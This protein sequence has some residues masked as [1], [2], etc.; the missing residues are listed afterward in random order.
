MPS[1]RRFYICTLCFLGLLVATCDRVNIAVAAPSI[2]RERGWNTGQMGL[3]L[4]AFY[5]GYVAFMVP[6]GIWTDRF[7]PKR[8][9]AWGVSWWSTFTALTPV[10]SAL[11]GLCTVRALMGAGE[12]ATI[13]SIG[14]MLARW[15]APREYSRASALAW[16]GGYAGSVLAFPVASVILSGWGWRA[17]FYVFAGLGLLWLVLWWRIASDGVDSGSTSENVEIGGTAST[18]SPIQPPRTIPWKQI[19]SSPA[20]WAIFLLHFSSNWFT[21]FLMS[22]LPTYLR[23]SRHFSITNMAIGSALPFTCALVGTNVWGTCIDWLSVN[24]DRTRVNKFFLLLFFGAAIILISL[25][26]VSSPLGVVFLLCLAAL[27]MTGATPVFASGALDLM[28]NSAGTFAGMQNT[29]A[30]LSGVL[31]PAMT[32]Y[33][34][35]KIG[36]AAAF[37]ATASACCLGIVAYAIM[38]S[39]TPIVARNAGNEPGRD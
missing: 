15:F 4:S 18:G 1:P 33:L 14:A 25:H 6:S 24:H 11:T 21:Y 9:F 17:I 3:A 35:A 34:A 29:V 27:L 12:S 30:N 8:S 19:L 2:M 38:G 13:P 37:A 36:W 20:A 10:A 32:G 31:A 23:L 39:A 16:S 28:P 26:W 22:W 5:A 7:G